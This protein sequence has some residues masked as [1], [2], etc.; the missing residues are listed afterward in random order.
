MILEKINDHY[1]NLIAKYYEDYDV[2]ITK[3]GLNLEIENESIIKMHAVC[4]SM[5]ENLLLNHIES[6]LLFAQNRQMPHSLIHLIDSYQ[7]QY[8]ETYYIEAKKEYQYYRFNI[9]HKKYEYKVH[10]FIDNYFNEGTIREQLDNFIYKDVK[11]PEIVLKRIFEDLENTFLS[12]FDIDYSKYNKEVVLGSS[13]R[14]DFMV[15]YTNLTSGKQ[16]VIHPIEINEQT[17]DVFFA[18]KYENILRL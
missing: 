4:R 10:T 2:K 7:D 18:G 11:L 6:V 9:Y 3:K 1:E 12:G 8:K 14:S 17:G 5:P 16:L 15:V 13:D